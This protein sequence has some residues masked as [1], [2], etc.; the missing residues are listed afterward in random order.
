[1]DKQFWLSVKKNKF[2]LPT[3]HAVLPLTEEL[4]SYLASTDPELRDTIGLEAFYHWLDQG[5]YSVDDVRGFVP[6]LIANLKIGLGETESDFVFLHSF[7]ILWLALIMEND[8]KKPA[9]MDE[10][11]ASILEAALAYFAAERD[12]RGFDP[13]KGWAHAIAHSADLFVAL[14]RSSHTDVGDH[15]KILDCVADKLRDATNWTYIYGEDARLAVAV[16]E[17]F[18]RGTL[19]VD[20]VKNWLAFLSTDWNNSW[21]DEGRARAFFNGR[22]FLR[23]LHWKTLKAENISDK[24]TILGMLRDTLDQISP[25]IPPE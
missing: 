8:T 2:A 17:V 7:S 5:L 22:N 11:I 23:A 15:I 4:F 18:V 13:V 6:R 12:L 20:Q 9:L 1:V 16:V 14:A 3:G 24:E 19:S 21:W 10:E 25:F